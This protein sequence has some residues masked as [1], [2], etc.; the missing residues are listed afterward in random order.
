MKNETVH[1]A[2]NWIIIVFALA[3][4]IHHLKIT[5]AYEAKLKLEKENCVETNSSSQ[6][7]ES[8]FDELDLPCRGFMAV[9]GRDK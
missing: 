7:C 5:D 3:L 4:F 9:I 1:L 6:F 8:L 2:I